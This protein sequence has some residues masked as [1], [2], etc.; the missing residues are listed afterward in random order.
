[1]KEKNLK[2]KESYYKVIK[3]MTDKQAGE[4]VKGICAYA[5]EDKDFT[6]KDGYLRGLFMYVKQNLD[7]A[8]VSRAYGKK[9]AIIS[10]ALK[11]GQQND[12]SG[13][14]IIAIDGGD[15]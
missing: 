15:L 3:D 2:F 8:N 5:F 10:K 1:V 9:G 11:K 7:E 13:E 4:F 12:L 6:T 14:I